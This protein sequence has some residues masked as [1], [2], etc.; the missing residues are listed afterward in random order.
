MLAGN[1]MAISLKSI[2]PY[3]DMNGNTLIFKGDPGNGRS[4]D[5][6]ISGKNNSLIIH[7]DALF[8]RLRIDFRGDNNCIKIGR[9]WGPR[10]TH[11]F[12]NVGHGCVVDIGDD[13][14]TTDTVY[15]VAAEGARVCIGNDC[16][17]ATGVELRATDSHAIYQQDGGARLNHSQDVIVGDHCW[18][19]TQ[20]VI[21]PGA[22]LGT[23]SVLGHRATLLDK[24][25]ENAVVVGTPARAVRSGIE[26]RRPQTLDMPKPVVV[27][28]PTADVTPLP[29]SAMPRI[30]VGIPA[31]GRPKLLS[32]TLASVTGQTLDP[33]Y[34]EILVV[35]DASPDP[36][37]GAVI[38]RAREQHPNIRSIRL[39]NNSGGASV[40]RNT[41]IEHASGDYILFL[42][43]DDTIGS[44]AL[45]RIQGYLKQHPVDFLSISSGAE[46]GRSVRAI[47]Q[48]GR[49]DLRQ[50]L[51]GLTINKVFRT[52][53]LR[54]DSSLR[55][56]P[57]FRVN[58]D[59]EFVWKAV[60]AAS[61]H[62][63]LSG[64]NFYSF[65]F[66]PKDETHLS[67]FYRD[68][69]RVAE[70]IDLKIAAFESMTDALFAAAPR[71]QG[72]DLITLCTT[73]LLPRTIEIMAIPGWIV[74]FLGP[75]QQVETLK[76]LSASVKLR[77][78]P[79]VD[80]TLSPKTKLAKLMKAIRTEDIEALRQACRIP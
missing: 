43:S 59:F 38:D 74:R 12:I 17:L 45:E 72:S 4:V 73:R 21:M 27:A 6:L 56:D 41:V 62:A 23:G 2:S 51:S 78:P 13:V 5:I 47:T 16:M 58:E 48:T 77:I 1:E 80:A 30:T 7:P 15:I 55:F 44:E 50:A 66:Q 69:T 19:A 71:L 67:L 39:A 28:G 63:S 36:E 37:V 26:W 76:R 79:E 32:Q 54:A 60:L 10:P 75:Q 70:G 18:L 25:P 24:A 34:F 49:E 31:Y 65:S 22:T 35:D 68:R 11:W 8:S 52:A 53:L 61:S 57:R 9:S 14:T 46:G 40:P 42:D 64:Y 29:D 33:A 20:A 3:A